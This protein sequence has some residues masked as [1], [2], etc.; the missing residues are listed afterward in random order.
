MNQNILTKFISQHR[1]KRYDLVANGDFEKAMRMYEANIQL[2][3]AYYS[4]LT[5]VEVALRNI[6]DET[7]STELNDTNWLINGQKPYKG[8]MHDQ[9]L[10]KPIKVGRDKYISKILKEVQSAQG[11]VKPPKRMTQDKLISS[12]SFGFWTN[13]FER[14]HF[15]VLNASPMAIFSHIPPSIKRVQVYTKLTE[16][17]KFRN[18]V[19]HNEPICFSKGPNMEFD[20]TN[21][22]EVHDLIIDILTWMDV[23]LSLWATQLNNVEVELARCKPFNHNKTP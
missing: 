22:K 6:L 15:S 11:A 5:I 16:I 14:K 18:R 3:Q 21:A 12:V 2:S 7:I 10:L 20:L 1:F 19:Y 23:D 13:L 4:L 17:R 9:R 8:F